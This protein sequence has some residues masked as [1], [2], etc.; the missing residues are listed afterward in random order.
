[1]PRGRA[2]AD[3]HRERCRH[4]MACSLSPVTDVVLIVVVSVSSQCWQ[5]G[6]LGKQLFSHSHTLTLFLRRFIT[7]F[8]S[9]PNDSASTGS[10]DLR[11]LRAVKVLRPLRLVS[12]IP[13]TYEAAFRIYFLFFAPLA[14][15]TIY[16]YYYYDFYLYP[17]IVVGNFSSSIL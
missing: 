1:M 7:I 17:P 16:Y 9:T 11:T 4:D 10:F 8:P 6:P 2:P 12:G 14:L 5:C 13:S 15:S 3:C